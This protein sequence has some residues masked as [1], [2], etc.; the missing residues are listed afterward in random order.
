MPFHRETNH[1]RQIA[2]LRSRAERFLKTEKFILDFFPDSKRDVRQQI[3]RLFGMMH[4]SGY[5]GMGFVDN[6]PRKHP[7]RGML[8]P[9]KLQDIHEWQTDIGIII[10]RTKKKP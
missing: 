3:P 1:D 7:H 2:W 4:L 8:S 6:S 5:N 9:L 10:K